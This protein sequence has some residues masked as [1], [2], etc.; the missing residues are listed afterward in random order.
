MEYIAISRGKLSGELYQSRNLYGLRRRNV[1][2]VP[3]SR[4][5]SR[6]DRYQSPTLPFTQVCI[7]FTFTLVPPYVNTLSLYD[8]NTQTLRF[9]SK[10]KL[11][12]IPDILHACWRSSGSTVQLTRL[13]WLGRVP[14]R[15][16]NG[17]WNTLAYGFRF[18]K[19]CKVHMRF[20]FLNIYLIS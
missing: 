14:F 5:W 11:Y 20:P 8:A 17:F 3:F 2:Q 9:L 6:V 19:R 4:L 7:T 10:R 12:F 15:F 13:W 16:F 1:N 18:S